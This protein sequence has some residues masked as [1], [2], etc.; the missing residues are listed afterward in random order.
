[1]STLYKT[2]RNVRFVLFRKNLSVTACVGMKTI[3]KCDVNFKTTKRLNALECQQLK[4]VSCHWEI[5]ILQ[6]SMPILHLKWEIPSHDG[7]L[8]FKTEWKQWKW[9]ING[10]SALAIYAKW[11]IKFSVSHTNNRLKSQESYWVV[12]IPFSP[13]FLFR[14]SRFYSS[15]VM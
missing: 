7:M 5:P 11:S 8:F 4:M 13:N 14:S 12:A 9:T 6:R 2:V 10:F 1:M 3:W 15:F